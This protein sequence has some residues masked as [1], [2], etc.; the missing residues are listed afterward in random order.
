M[1]F[2]TV[3]TQKYQ[4]NRLLIE[5]DRLV[6]MKIIED[7][8]FAQIGHSDYSPQNYQYE[9][10]LNEQTFEQKMKESDVIITH[11]GV[12]NIISALKSNKKVIAPPRLKKYNEH[13][14]DHQLQIVSTFIEKKYIYGAIDIKDIE[15]TILT[16]DTKKINKYESNNNKIISIVENYIQ[17]HI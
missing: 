13:A 7:Q 6:E 14:D 3:G 4:F 12:G 10:F 1:I 16:I 8:I 9:L 15:E 11:G 17:N 5:I 2:L